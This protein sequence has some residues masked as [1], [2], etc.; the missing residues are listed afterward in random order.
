MFVYIFKWHLG[1]VYGWLGVI[2]H[3][4]CPQTSLYNS[5]FKKS[6]TNVMSAT[7]KIDKI[8]NHIQFRTV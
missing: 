1:G 2:W 8:V 6:E 3:G 7:R 4:F 5:S